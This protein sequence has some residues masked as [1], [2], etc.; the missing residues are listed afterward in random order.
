V[1][2]AL[3][4]AD[5]DWVWVESPL[6][7]R[8]KVPAVLYAGARPDVVC[9][10]FELGHRAYG[11]WAEGRGANPNWLIV[12]QTTGLTGALAPFATRVKIYKSQ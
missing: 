7:E 6:G 9:M 8:I 12:N 3:G 10:P 2:R 5:D 11:R 1:A 4:I